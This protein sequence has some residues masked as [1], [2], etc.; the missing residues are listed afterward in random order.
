MKK[1]TCNFLVQLDCLQRFKKIFSNFLMFFKYF[2]WFDC[3]L[4]SVYKIFFKIGDKSK[5]TA[6]FMTKYLCRLSFL[7]S[8]HF[9]WVL[10]NVAWLCIASWTPGL[11]GDAECIFILL[12]HTKQ[13][14][15]VIFCDMTTRI[16][17]SKVWKIDGLTDMKFEI[18][19]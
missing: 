19:I 15:L 10:I 11:E 14:L 16:G 17:N 6:I 13:L 2:T 4:V 8:I 7:K 9:D 5:W 1:N 12:T 3:N 18:V